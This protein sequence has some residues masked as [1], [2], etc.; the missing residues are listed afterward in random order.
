MKKILVA[1]LAVVMSFGLVLAGCNNSQTHYSNGLTDF[2]NEVDSNGGFAVVKGDYVYFINGVASNTDDNTFGKPVTGALVRIKK[3]DLADAAARDKEQIKTEMV[4]PSLFVAGDL[5]SGFY[6]FENDNN[7]YF[8]SPYT[9]KDREGKVQND[10]LSFVRASLDGKEK[11]VLLTVDDNT[12]AYR[13]VKNGDKVVLLLKT[14]VKDETS[15]SDTATRAAIVAY[16]AKTGEKI[17][18]SE[19]VVEY[20]FGEGTDVYFTVAP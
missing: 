14:T 5:T 16:D 3:S 10:R 8:A 6:M 13:Y 11:N 7:V 12:T 4:I 17:F 1:L 20:A 18:T 15:D 19:K 9:E 2:G